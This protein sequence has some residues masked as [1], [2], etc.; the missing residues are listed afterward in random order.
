M[1]TNIKPF[2]IYTDR[3]SLYIKNINESSERL[4]SN[5][6]A[7]SANIDKNNNIHILAIDNI[8]RV[9]HFFN[10]DGTWK[11]NIIRKYFNN[12]KNI[13]DMRLYILNDYFN[14]FVVE[15]YPLDDN[16]FKISH[17]NFNISNYNIFRHTINKVFKDNSSI[18]KL[19]ID[20]LS[21]IVFQYKTIDVLSREIY[22]NIIIFNSISRKWLTS[23]P[24]LRNS[25]ISVNEK[26]LS[27]NIKSDIFEYCYSIKYKL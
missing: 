4:S 7:Y 19:N 18:Y 1:N 9:I 5:I 16:L 17:L 25:K 10:N 23:T 12:A 8:G 26:N 14:I 3:N 20:E 22:D 11:K 27:T 6:Y 13:K 24:L 2:Y 15:K 21:N